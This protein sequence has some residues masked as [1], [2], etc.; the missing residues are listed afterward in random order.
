MKV[1]IFAGGC[2]TRLAEE[3]HIHPSTTVAYNKEL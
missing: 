2:G 1:V 3:T